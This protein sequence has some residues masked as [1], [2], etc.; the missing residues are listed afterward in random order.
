MK[1]YGPGEPIKTIEAFDLAL[2]K[3]VLLYVKNWDKTAAPVVIAN[4]QYWIVKR[5]IKAGQI[6]FA[7]KIKED[8]NGRNKK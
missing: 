5:F 6:C 7:E 8:S 3:G 1:T 2:E 4:M